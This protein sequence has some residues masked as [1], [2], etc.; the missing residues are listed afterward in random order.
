M[1]RPSPLIISPLIL[2]SNFF[3]CLG[4]WCLTIV[5]VCLLVVGSWVRNV[6][7]LCISASMHHILEYAGFFIYLK[8]LRMFICINYVVCY[9]E[10]CV[11]YC[12]HCEL[13]LALM[14]F[15]KQILMT[16][17]VLKSTEVKFCGK[18]RKSMETLLQCMYWS[19][20]VDWP[21]SHCGWSRGGIELASDEGIPQ[22]WSPWCSTQTSRPR[23]A[24][25]EPGKPQSGV[26]PLHSPYLLGCR[27][28]GGKECGE[29]T[30]WGHTL[31][32]PAVSLKTPLIHPTPF[33]PLWNQNKTA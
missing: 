7:Y 16:G 8:T 13:S 3:F 6:L 21:G 19:R 22:C 31:T 27:A 33:S 5:L 14:L 30:G 23:T 28:P 1:L 15:W 26:E 12:W 24:G 10:V 4:V 32:E 20:S 2:R 18:K 29:M 25:C 17:C 11:K 9:T